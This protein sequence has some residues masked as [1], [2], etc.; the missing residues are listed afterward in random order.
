MGGVWSANLDTGALKIAYQLSYGTYAG[1]SSAFL[2]QAITTNVSGANSNQPPG[3]GLFIGWADGLG[4]FGVDQTIAT[5]YTGGQSFLVSDMIPI[6]TLF[7]PTTAG[8]F[9]FKLS[10]PLLLGESV[11]LQ[12]GSSLDDYSNNTFT[13]LGITQGT[14]PPYNLTTN[15]IVL[16]G[17]FPNKV[18]TQQWLLVKAILTARATNPSFARLVQLRVI[19]ATAHDA[20]S[21]GPCHSVNH[22]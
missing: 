22:S 11:E 18:Q 21:L 17:L 9:E 4:N 10:T 5:P 8:Q 1:F 7:E 12:V 15:Q 20:V 19:G 16:S 2:A 3:G 14:D 13:S 6:G